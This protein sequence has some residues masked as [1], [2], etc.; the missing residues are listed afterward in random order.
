M[1]DYLR[2]LPE[3]RVAGWYRRLADRMAL[4]TVDGEP[5]LAP[6][7]LRQWLD[8]R[9]ATSVFTFPPPTHLKESTYVTRVLTEHRSIFLSLSAARNGRIVGVLPRLRGDSGFTRW[10]LTDLLQMDYHSL[11]EVGSNVFEIGRIQL[12]G[13]RAE[14]DLLTA[15][16]GFQ[17]HSRVWLEGV[18]NQHQ[19][20]VDVR[21]ILWSAHI[22]DRYDWDYSEHFTVPNPDH[23]SR[24][25]D[26]VRPQD[27]ELTVYHSNARRLERAGLAAPYDLRCHHWH[28][29]SLLP[30]A[31]RSYTLGQR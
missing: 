10:D 20:T 6:M 26:A 14:R 1:T 30:G 23:G 22:E 15:L 24:D 13:T 2:T 17:L 25:A 28:V 16:R 18:R 8:N 3:A 19:R 29:T 4:E 12:T 5:A 21:I 31:R 27:E 11:V 9:D 7:L